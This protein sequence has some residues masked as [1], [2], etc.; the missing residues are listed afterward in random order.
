MPSQIWTQLIAPQ[1]QTSGATNFSFTT[2]KSVINPQCLV[3]TPRNFFNI[4]ARLRISVLMGISNIVTTPG[5]ITFSVQLGP[6]GT[7]AVWSS[8]AIQLNATAHTLL[9]ASLVINLSCQVVG[10]GTTAKFMGQGVLTGVMFTKTIAAT[11]AWGRVSAADTAVS[12]V[13]INVPVTAPAQGGGF[14]STVGNLLDFYTAMSISNA[15]NGIQIYDYL[16]E[17]LNY[18]G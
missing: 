18:N 7:I 2:A 1:A 9:P 8:G 12:D 4:G 13:T 3:D 6:T 11:D 16:V 17:S 15:A 10:T 5:T 14:D